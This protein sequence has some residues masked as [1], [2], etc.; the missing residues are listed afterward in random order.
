[1][2]YVQIQNLCTDIKVRANNIPSKLVD[3]YNVTGVSKIS[4]GHSGIGRIDAVSVET[5]KTI[6]SWET[7]AT[8]YA[9]ILA[10]AG[11]L[12][13]NGGIDRYLR[14]F[15]QNDGKVL[16]Q[17]RLGSHVSGAPVS[18]SRNGRQYIAVVAGGGFGGG[19]SPTRFPEIDQS[20]GSNMVYV[21]AL[22]EK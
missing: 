13:F 14:A 21:F 17:T 1:M 9:P 18:F 22:P 7:K 11:G 12:V 15:D 8:N 10:T 5:G 3:G 2:L 20:S 6:W 4:P 16:W 19:I